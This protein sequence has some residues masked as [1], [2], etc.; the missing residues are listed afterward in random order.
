MGNDRRA[1]VACLLCG[2]A[3]ASFSCFRLFRLL[4]DFTAEGK[5]RRMARRMLDVVEIEFVAADHVRL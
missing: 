3:G 4:G 2:A 1:V 5:A